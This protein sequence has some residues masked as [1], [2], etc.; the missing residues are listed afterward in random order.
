MA[1]TKKFIKLGVG[2]ASFSDA[3]TGINLANDAVIAVKPHATEIP[4]IK[5]RL[6]HGHLALAS[7]EEYT[8]YRKKADKLEKESKVEKVKEENLHTEGKM[9]VDDDDEDG[10]DEDED[11][12]EDDDTDDH[13]ED[14]EG[15]KTKASMIADL[16]ASSLVDA[17]KK[18]DLQKLSLT[19]LIALHN[20]IIAG[21]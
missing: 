20:K 10:P 13:D 18:K 21:K 2:A 7:E 15:Q 9:I 5:E 1:V 3:A 16:Q 12:D 8:A 14:E 6:Q 4:H 11:E 19:K 17:K